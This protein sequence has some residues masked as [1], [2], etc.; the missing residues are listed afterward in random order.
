[1]GK[2]WRMF[3]EETSQFL[4]K[5]ASIIHG[6]SVLNAKHKKILMQIKNIIQLKDEFR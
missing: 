1:M 5:N 6:S 3:L 4:I 2:V